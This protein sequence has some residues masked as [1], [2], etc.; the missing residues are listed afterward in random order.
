[1]KI[2]SALISVTVIAFLSA[3]VARADIPGVAWQAG[4]LVM[5][6][7]TS[8]AGDV[9]YNWSTET[10]LLRQRNGQI[11][12]Y[13]AHTVRQFGWFDHNQHKYRQ[14]LSLASPTG[15][16]VILHRFYELCLDGSLTV[17]R[18]LRR[19]HG[20]FKRTFSH[21]AHY[22]DTQELAQTSEQFDY[23]VYDEGE[24]LTFD[25]FHS[26]IYTPKLIT[27]DRELQHF[28]RIHNINDR[29][30]LGR[31]VLI[32]H[33]NFLMKQDQKTASIRNASKVPD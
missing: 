2:T 13:S 4:E 14:F 1:M 3:E 9:S 15:S 29:S 19:P 30:L 31:L 20:L 8:L 24:F 10:V 27:H 11:R 25:R 21:P 22:A 16:D 12:S 23:F 5:W 17:I 7:N 28:Q 32:D 6:N 18:R 33:Y 26:D